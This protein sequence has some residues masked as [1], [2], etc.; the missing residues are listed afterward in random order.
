[1]PNIWYFPGILNRIRDRKMKVF[2]T[3]KHYED[4]REK[5]KRNLPKIVEEI[6]EDTM[7]LVIAEVDKRGVFELP[8]SVHDE[9]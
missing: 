3:K 8:T 5:D 7:N 1:M 4:K 6:N 9:F 2:T